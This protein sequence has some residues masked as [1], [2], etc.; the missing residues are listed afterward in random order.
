MKVIILAAGKGSRL[1]EADLPKPLT[2][3]VT[4]QSILEYQLDILS[5][6]LS[7]DCVIVIVG[8]H[9]EQ[10]MERFPDLMFVYNSN[11]SAENTAKSLLRALKKIDED[12]LWLNGDVVMHPSVIEA[13]LR[14]PRT[15]MVVNV[16][17][18]GDEEVKY[19]QDKDGRILAVSKQVKNPLGEAL[20]INFWQRKDLNAFRKNLGRCSDSDYFE[21]GIEL[22][23][24]EGMDVRTVIVDPMLCAEIDF[25]EDLQKANEMLRK[26]STF[27]GKESTHEL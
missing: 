22:C 27:R 21:R 15:S 2:P 8:Y 7:L 24:D 19:R 3:L 14:K 10:I 6:F 17:P 1:G 25:P 23:I 9:K 5:K 11:Y 4:G 13:V 18:V 12:V 20:G 26:W 16:G